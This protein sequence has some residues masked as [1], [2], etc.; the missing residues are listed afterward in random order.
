MTPRARALSAATVV[1]AAI[2]GFAVGASLGPGRANPVVTR[3]HLAAPGYLA[4]FLE[5]VRHERWGDALRRTGRSYQ[6]LHDEAR[7][8]VAVTTIPA[9]ARHDAI[10]IAGFEARG[11]SFDQVATVRGSLRTPEGAV[12]FVAVLTDEGPHWYVQELDVGGQRLP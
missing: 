8:R 6:D 12:S 3:E 11:G 7:L 5:D 2:V 10:E 1:L 9:L 4:A